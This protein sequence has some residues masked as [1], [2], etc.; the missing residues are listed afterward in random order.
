VKL[1][2][3]ITNQD[4]ERKGKER[5]GK[6]RKGKERKGKERQ[7]KARQSTFAFLLERI[8]YVFRVL[9]GIEF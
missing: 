2:L 1:C 8:Q 7:G 4:K 6:E 3:R 5:K 9:R